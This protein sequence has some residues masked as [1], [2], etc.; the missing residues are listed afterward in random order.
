[1]VVFMTHRAILS[2]VFSG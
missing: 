1:M 2:D